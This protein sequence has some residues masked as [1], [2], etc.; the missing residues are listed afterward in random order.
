MCI[1]CICM[2][3]MTLRRVLGVNS[4]LEDHPPNNSL[5]ARPTDRLCVAQPPISHHVTTHLTHHLLSHLLRTSNVANPPSPPPPPSHIIHS[6]QVRRSNPARAS[7]P[8][9][10]E[11]TEPMES[12]PGLLGL[13]CNLQ[14]RRKFRRLGFQ[15]GEG[16]SCEGK[17]KVRVDLDGGAWG[18]FGLARARGGK[19]AVWDGLAG[20]ERGWVREATTLGTHIRRD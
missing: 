8:R 20:N 19:E 16:A 5:A 15:A 1:M 4:T 3:D 13:Q 10:L 2:K 11:I 9:E 12:Q 17:V 6:P 14:A 7:T 18:W